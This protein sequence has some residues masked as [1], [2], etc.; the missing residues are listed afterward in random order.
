MAS[1][2]EISNFSQLGISVTWQK[3]WWNEKTGTMFYTATGI[4]ALTTNL[5]NL[6]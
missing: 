2:L 1:N 4:S 6:F 3:L 5:I